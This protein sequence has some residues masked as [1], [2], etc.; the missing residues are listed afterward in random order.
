M[1]SR[2]HSQVTLERDI[3]Y[4]PHALG[5]GKL[6]YD[7][8]VLLEKS[9]PSFEA[10]GVNSALDNCTVSVSRFVVIDSLTLSIPLQA[11]RPD[12]VGWVGW[13]N[14]SGATGQ[15]GRVVSPFI[16][17]GPAYAIEGGDTVLFTAKN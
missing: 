4:T 3:V 16:E 11:T 6:M 7:F 5:T 8:E 9:T 14:D 10:D 1:D 13:V 12:V 2:L 15:E 17:I